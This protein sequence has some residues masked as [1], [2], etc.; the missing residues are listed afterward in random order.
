MNVAYN[1]SE[2]IGNTPLLK[3]GR[4]VPTTTH[5]F[6]KC[7]FMNPTASVKDRIGYSMIDDAIS[8]G[9]K[10]SSSTTI[11]EPTS[12]NT[13]IALA[14]ICASMGLSLVLT[15][16]ESM[17]LERQRLLRAMGARLELTPAELGM[18]G[19][20]D[21]AEALSR[22]IPE[23]LI[24]QQFNN[25]AN[26][27]IHR[28]T[29]AE[30]I[31]R[32]LDGQV[33]IFVCG[34]GTGG[35][36]TGVGEVLKQR[37]PAVQVVAVEPATSSVLQGGTPGTHKIQGLGAG[38]VPSVL[39]TSIID[40]TISISDE[41]AIHTAREIANKEGVLVGVSS[42]ANVHAAMQVARRRENKDKHIITILADGGERYLS[43]HLFT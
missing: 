4:M 23:S 35:T 34:V 2:L 14:S 33:D 1:V 40:E 32:D 8:R 37:N 20:V 19:A 36:L 39:N 38:F 5:I 10:I 24:L 25:P 31:W 22:E 6:A 17:S 16:P 42:G 43:T 13:G 41:D 7:E 27:D 15:M 29:T 21:R 12:G 26:P 18:K 11:I 28:Q 30:E 3:L 9:A